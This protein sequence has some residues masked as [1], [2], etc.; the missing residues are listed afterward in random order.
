MFSDVNRLIFNKH[1]YAKG[2]ESEET[3][4]GL[5]PSFE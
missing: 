5:K 4:P 3:S 1:V 2:P